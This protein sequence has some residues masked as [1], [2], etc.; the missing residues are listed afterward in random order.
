MANFVDLDNPARFV[1]S[2]STKTHGFT[3]ALRNPPSFDLYETVPPHH[4]K[5]NAD[6]TDVE[7]MTAAEKAA[8]DADRDAQLIAA[9]KAAASQQAEGPGVRL[10]IGA[11]LEVIEMVDNRARQGQPALNKRQLKNALRQAITR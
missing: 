8:V 3:R 4:I 10:W 7:E 5:I 2:R 1:K 11:L 9:E 6:E